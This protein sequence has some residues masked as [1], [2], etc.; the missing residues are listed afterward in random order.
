[1]SGLTGGN[2]VFVH[3]YKECDGKKGGNN[4]ALLV[5]KTL[6]KLGLLDQEKG[7]GNKL[8]LVFDN[9]PGQKKQATMCC[10]WCHT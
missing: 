6:D 2:Q 1:M 5:M 8:N 3:I 9:W 4:V 7:I 10:I